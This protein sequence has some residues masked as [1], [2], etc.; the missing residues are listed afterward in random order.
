MCD[1]FLF[2]LIGVLLGVFIVFS[3][4]HSHFTIDEVP[5]TVSTSPAVYFI[6]VC[7]NKDDCHKY[8]KNSGYITDK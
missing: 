2:T 7:T 1:N 5:P 6:P 8:L 3:T 4:P